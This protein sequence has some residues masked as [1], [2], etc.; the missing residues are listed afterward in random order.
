MIASLGFKDK[1]RP[2]RYK[3]EGCAIRNVSKNDLLNIIREFEKLPYESYERKRPKHEPTDSYFYLSI[4]LDKCMIR[5]DALNSHSYPVRSK[6]TAPSLH[7]FLLKGT[8][9]KSSSSKKLYRIAVPWMRTNQ[10][11][12]LSPIVPRTKTN[13][14]VLLAN[15]KTQIM[16]LHMMCRAILMPL[17]FSNAEESFWTDLIFHM[18]ERTLTLQENYSL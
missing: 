13:I 14:N 6:I 12:S 2:H 5:D 4:Q 8:N 16:R 10:K 15:K 11:A 17:T 7:V 3:K 9:Q 1:V 18:N